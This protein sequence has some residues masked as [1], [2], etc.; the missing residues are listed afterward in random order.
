MN[1]LDIA[2]EEISLRFLGGFLAMFT[3]E[4]SSGVLLGF[5]FYPSFTQMMLSFLSLEVGLMIRF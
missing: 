3:F 4:F 2:S 1:S 5:D